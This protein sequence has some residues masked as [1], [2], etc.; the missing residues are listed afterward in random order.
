MD[1]IELTKI[2]AYGYTGFLAEEQALGQWFEVDL[3]MDIDLTKAGQSD[4]LED[5]LDY[6]SVIATTK[7]IITTQKFVLVERLAEAIV[8]A[9]MG[10]K[11]VQQ[12][13]VRLHKPAAPIPDFGGC[14]TIEVTRAR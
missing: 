8:F 9:V 13:R 11:P 1:R 5:T 7:Q 12:V 10:F 2:R 14:I 3:L 6:R 4:R